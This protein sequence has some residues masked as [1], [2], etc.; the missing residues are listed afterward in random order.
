MMS[1]RFSPSPSASPLIDLA[2]VV[3]ALIG[4]GF[5][6]V[7]QFRAARHGF[8]S[9]RGSYAMLAV[10]SLL[11]AGSYVWVLFTGDF[12]TWSQFMRPVDM[13]QWFLL[14]LHAHH[15]LRTWRKVE[16]RGR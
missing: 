6:G 13:V 15:N 8:P 5:A 4:S 11:Y 3:I 1:V 16:R 9:S 2:V 10:P 7:A 12:A 14:A